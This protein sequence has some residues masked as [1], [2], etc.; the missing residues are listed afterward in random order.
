MILSIIIC[1]YTATIKDKF[2]NIIIRECCGLEKNVVTKVDKG[3]LGGSDMQ[4][5]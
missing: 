3:C 2:Q 5:G 1:I 4:K